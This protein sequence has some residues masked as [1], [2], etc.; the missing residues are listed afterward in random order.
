MLP[1]LPASRENFAK[2]KPLAAACVRRDRRRFH[3]SGIFA[4]S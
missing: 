1:L 3:V 4:L 2:L